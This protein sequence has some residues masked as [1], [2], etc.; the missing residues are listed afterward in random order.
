MNDW[1]LDEDRNMLPIL[2]QNPDGQWVKGQS[3]IDPKTAYKL[4]LGRE[5][6]EHFADRR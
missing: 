1:T 3:L 4:S 2:E 6:A 5:L